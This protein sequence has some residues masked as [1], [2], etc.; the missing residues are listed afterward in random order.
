MDAR[1][2]GKGEK[3]ACTMNLFHLISAIRVFLGFRS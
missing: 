1:D 3:L 2:H